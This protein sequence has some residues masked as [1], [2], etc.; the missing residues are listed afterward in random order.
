MHEADRSALE[1]LRSTAFR[2]GAG[3]PARRGHQLP[4][5]AAIRSATT[6]AGYGESRVAAE[7]FQI[8]LLEA[9]LRCASDDVAKALCRQ[10]PGFCTFAF[11]EG[12]GPRVVP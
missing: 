4:P 5:D 7:R 2:E 3:P 10:K 11:D 1:T 9:V 12:I 8:V 6:N